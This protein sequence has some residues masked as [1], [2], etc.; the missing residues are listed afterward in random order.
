MHRRG[1]ED[2]EVPEGTE[3]TENVV[4]TVT[5]VAALILEETEVAKLRT[6]TSSEFSAT[7]ELSAISA[8][9]R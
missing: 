6:R 2:A 5:D 1:T 3:V 8:P 7:S 9:L 4:L